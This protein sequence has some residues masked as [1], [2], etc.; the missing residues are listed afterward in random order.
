MKFSDWLERQLLERGLRPQDLAN[1]GDI[2]PATVSAILND[3]REVGPDVGR[4][5]ARAL[6]LPQWVVFRAGGLLTEDPDYQDKP[7]PPLLASMVRD[8]SRATEAQQRAMYAV[9]RAMLQ[10]MGENGK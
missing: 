9:L 1:A 2:D 8:L 5:I 4:R 7:M 10:H 6:K 3:R